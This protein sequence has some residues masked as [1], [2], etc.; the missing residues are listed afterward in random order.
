MLG[1]LWGIGAALATAVTPM[2]HLLGLSIFFAGIAVACR[3]GGSGWRTATASI[4]LRSTSPVVLLASLLGGGLGFA[5][6]AGL[7]LL[8]LRG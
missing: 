4:N 1:T 8:A 7:A 6:Y 3:S 2:R 5:G